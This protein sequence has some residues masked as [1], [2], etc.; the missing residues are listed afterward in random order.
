MLLK[1][2]HL[3]LNYLQYLNLD[4]QNTDIFHNRD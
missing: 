2:S 1:R 4:E 3:N